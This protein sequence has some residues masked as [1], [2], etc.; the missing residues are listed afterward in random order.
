[1]I[2]AGINTSACLLLFSLCVLK[3]RRPWCR[4][5]LCPHCPLLLVAVAHSSD[6][7]FGWL[8]ESTWLIKKCTSRC[9]NTNE[10]D[11]ICL[12][13]TASFG[14]LIKVHFMLPQSRENTISTCEFNNRKRVQQCACLERENFRGRH[15]SIITWWCCLRRRSAKLDYEYVFQLTHMARGYKLWDV[16]IRTDVNGDVLHARKR[17][18]SDRSH[19]HSSINLLRI[20]SLLFIFR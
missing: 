20:E 14:I 4:Q 10:N 9:T 8:T 12:W 11:C 3:W 15:Q 7:L 6:V 5:I 2:D 13:V 16:I 1:M 18:G 19:H 17:L